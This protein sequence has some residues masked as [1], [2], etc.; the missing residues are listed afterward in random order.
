[1][2]EG[3]TLAKALTDVRQRM[4]DLQDQY[5]R[6]SAELTKLR[7]AVAF[8]GDGIN[9]APALA[10]ADIGVAIGTGTDIAVESADVGLREG[11]AALRLGQDRHADGGRGGAVELEPE[12]GVERQHHGEPDPEGEGPGGGLGDPAVEDVEQARAGTVPF[13]PSQGPAHPANPAPG[14]RACR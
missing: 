3:D 4:A 7:V 2:S 13:G 1:M 14:C 8:V 10:E 11:L 12:R 9:D 6:V 5:E